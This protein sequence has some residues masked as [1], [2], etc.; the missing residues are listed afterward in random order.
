MMSLGILSAYIIGSV[1]RW[2]TLAWICSTVAFS[3][4]IVMFALPESP[5]W[6]RSKYRF[7]E[8]DQ[9]TK[10]LKLQTPSIQLSA[11]DKA[12]AVTVIDKPPEKV[13]KVPKLREVIFTR[14]LLMPLTIGLMLLVLQQISGIDAIIF[15]TVEIFR[16]SGTSNIRHSAALIFL[17][18]RR[19]FVSTG[20]TIDEHLATIIVGGVQLVSNIASLFV[21][22]KAGRK[23]LLLGS[24][25]IMCVSMA[26]MGTAF[27]LNKNSM[28]TFGWVKI[29]D[30]MERTI[31]N[32]FDSEFQIPTAG[33]FN[34]LHDWILDWFRMHS[35]FAAGRN[36]PSHSSQHS[37]LDCRLF[38]SR[39]D[40]HCHQNVPLFGKGMHCTPG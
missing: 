6:L 24:A 18:S 31:R 13:E 5:V 14:P 39:R 17:T 27:Y 22:D 20:S 23:P 35:I 21:V 10:W 33:Q 32:W 19:V 28:N 26:S 7:R 16:E 4:C 8:A 30:I 25:V 38:Q 36:I 40:V 37:Q 2:D 9:S 29:E 34:R 12:I 11:A 1:A 3:L 15:F